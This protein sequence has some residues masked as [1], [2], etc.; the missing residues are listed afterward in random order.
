MKNSIQ[1]L[2]RQGNS[3][4]NNG[5]FSEL[6]RISNELLEIN[7]S[8]SDPWFFLSIVDTT[9]QKIKSALKF[10]GHAL[11]IA[12]TNAEYWV[13]KAKLHSMAMQA[14]DALRSA[15]TAL[16]HKP[17]SG[18]LLDTLGVVFS[19]LERH[20][21][22]RSALQQAVQAQPDNPQYVFNLASSEQFLGFTEEASQHYQQ[23]I[24]L[25]PHFYRAYWAL[26]ELEKNHKDVKRLQTLLDLFSNQTF[27]PEEGLYLGHA[28]SREYERQG[29]YE[30]AFRYLR[31]AKD[32]RRQGLNYAIDQDRAI[33]TTLKTM[34]SRSELNVQPS[35]L[36]KNVV[37]IIGMPRSGTT[38]VERILSSH[39][40]VVSFGELQEFPKAVK[41]VSGTKNRFMLDVEVIEKTTALSD[42]SAIGRTYLSNIRHRETNSRFF[43]DKLPLNFLYAGHIRK[44]LPAAKVILVRRN[45]LDVCVSN[46]RQL[47]AINNPY[48]NYHYRLEDTAAYICFFE[49]LATFW[50]R[51]F[52]DSI[53]QLKYEDLVKSPESSTRDVLKYLGLPWEAECLEFHKNQSSVSTASTMQVREPIYRSSIGYWNKY[54]HQIQEAIAIFRRHG[55]EYN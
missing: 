17:N 30:N 40:D 10:I 14:P 42:C 37:F 52:G 39:S 2:I 50:E 46:Y 34:F 33:F 32:A 18:I 9:R 22:A 55:I 3:A 6:E 43:V 12:P 27:T 13:Q 44:S 21:L 20:D 35:E 51:K 5:N 8:I 1:A 4:L 36:G 29:D 15:E 16:Q 31:Q 38:L 41:L 24:K 11:Q 19:R 49:E 54:Q 47:F 23:A 26:S 7:Q 45:P 48:Y 25:N 53:Y 28:I